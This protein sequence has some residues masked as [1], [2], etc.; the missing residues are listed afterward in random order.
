VVHDLK[1]FIFAAVLV[2][3][4]VLVIA[5]K[6]SPC[7][8]DSGFWWGVQRVMGNQCWAWQQ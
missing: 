7:R 8:H 3:T 1:S 6:Y 5:G 2:V 4:G